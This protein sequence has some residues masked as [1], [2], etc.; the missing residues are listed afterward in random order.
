[1]EGRFF[2]LPI[3]NLAEEGVRV[4][5]VDTYSQTYAPFNTNL[6]GA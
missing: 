5:V 2:R 6:W 3:D 1:M 4:T